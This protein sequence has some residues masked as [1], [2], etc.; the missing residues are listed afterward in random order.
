MG[1]S[2]GIDIRS[3]GALAEELKRPE[4]AVRNTL[5]DLGVVVIDGNYNHDRYLAA[6][7]E[8]SWLRNKRNEW[9]L[10]HDGGLGAVKY[11]LDPLKINIV[12]HEMSRA[13]YLMLEGP[14]RLRHFVK[15][16]YRNKWVKQKDRSSVCFDCKG[17][18]DETQGNQYFMFVCIEGKMAWAFS[19][20]QL[21]SYYNFLRTAPPSY[22]DGVICRWD[23]RTAVGG[24]LHFW[25]NEDCPS[26]LVDKKQ[27]GF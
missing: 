8:P 12:Q 7:S 17:L 6:F 4:A 15:L 16:Q 26:L 19:R 13:N 1:C 25:L 3:V 22:V 14:G 18:T 24:G 21:I 27:L 2:V 11:I 9:S 10:S 5:K 20:N 23:D